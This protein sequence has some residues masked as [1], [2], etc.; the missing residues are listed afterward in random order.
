MLLETEP[1]CT[2]FLTR[3]LVSVP[4]LRCIFVVSAASNRRPRSLPRGQS[5]GEKT[6]EKSVFD[7]ERNLTEADG[8]DMM[9]TIIAT[10]I[11]D[12]SALYCCRD[13][14]LKYWSTDDSPS[15][16][17]PST[18]T[19]ASVLYRNDKHYV[20]AILRGVKSFYLKN[21]Q[22]RLVLDLTESPVSADSYENCSKIVSGRRES[23][24]TILPRR[25]KFGRERSKNGGALLHW[26]YWGW[27]PSA[28]R[29]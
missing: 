29:I 11:H 10:C 7:F 2:T 22:L 19:G 17:A 25:V 9:F 15:N 8:A 16:Q 20:I 4:V 5:V 21:S 3:P 6:E 13:R 27:T 28:V 23:L 12:Y 1:A 26:F 18:C 14:M 24:R